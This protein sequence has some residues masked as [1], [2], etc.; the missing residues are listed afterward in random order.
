MAAAARD[1]NQM[2][3]QHAGGGDAGVPVILDGG[4]HVE[5]AAIDCGR[6]LRVGMRFEHGGRIWEITHAK[7]V[8]RGW[9]ARPVRARARSEAQ[10]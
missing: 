5:V 6:E 2:G 9:V 3:A 1:S 10:R 7:D 8:M 4:T